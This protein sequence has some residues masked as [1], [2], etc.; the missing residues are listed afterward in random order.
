MDREDGTE[1]LL[2]RD[3]AP[4]EHVDQ[5]RRLEEQIV[6]SLAAAD[7]GPAAVREPLTEEAQRLLVLRP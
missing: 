1:D 7:R 6:A 5:H 3:V 4:R 2:A